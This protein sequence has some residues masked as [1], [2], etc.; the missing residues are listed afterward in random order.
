MGE[1][2]RTPTRTHV[3]TDTQLAIGREIRSPSTRTTLMTPLGSTNMAP[4]HSNQMI[5]EERYHRLDHDHLEMILNITD[6]KT[7]V[8]TWKGDKKIFQ[9][10]EKPARSEF[11]DLPENICEFSEAP[12]QGWATDTPVAFWIKEISHGA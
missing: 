2:F 3:G 11:N 8:G 12:R 6:P 7:Y 1:N 5:V 10:L 9:L 4:P